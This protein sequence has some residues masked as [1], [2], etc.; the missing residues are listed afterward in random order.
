MSLRTHVLVCQATG[1]HK[2][3]LVYDSSSGHVYLEMEGNHD[4]SIVYTPVRV[5]RAALRDALFSIGVL[6]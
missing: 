2:C 3:K 1:R 5:D 4:A 6:P